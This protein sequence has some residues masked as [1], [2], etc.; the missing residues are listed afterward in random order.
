[1][2]RL[3]KARKQK[4]RRERGMP[5]RTV[6]REVG[7]AGQDSHL[8]E[9]RLSS[10]TVTWEQLDKDKVDRDPMIRSLSEEQR[11]QIYD[12]VA[13]N[14]AEALRRIEVLRERFPDS[15]TAINWMS[16]A[17]GRLGQIDRLRE[18]AEENYRRNPDYLF[19]RCNWAQMCMEED[20]LDEVEEIFDGKFDLKMLYP[21]RDVFH[22]TEVISFAHTMVQ[23]RAKLGDTRSAEMYLKIMKDLAPDHPSTADAERILHDSTL[24]RMLRRIS[25]QLR[26]GSVP[27]LAR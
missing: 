16:A 17:C 2:S 12:L 10:Y 15:P 24:M 9:L 7:N 8:A 23:Y 18:L 11:E 1:M 5:R 22:I 19:A 6:R 25:Q 13:D 14:P 21:H 3:N 27:R 26:R 20:R 4:R